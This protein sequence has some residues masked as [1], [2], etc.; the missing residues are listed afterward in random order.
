MQDVEKDILL[1]AAG[2]DLEAFET[3]YKTMANPIYN[4]A[5]RVVNSKE[6][7]EEVVQEVFLI[8]HQKLREFRFES[9]FKTW[10]YRITVNYAINYSKK[11]SKMRSVG[12]PQEHLLAAEPSSEDWQKR[13]EQDYNNKVIEELLG[14][15][16][17]EQRACVV[18]RSIEG[19][20][21]QQIADALKININTV[22]TRLKRAREKML[23][24]RKQVEYEQL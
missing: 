15:V 1:K 18:L 12:V 7:A 16:N 8:V 19:L 4:I 6:D 9:S 13:T 17:P 21:Y 11:I 24:S 23:L 20:S 5:R 10:V 2:G 3:V 22:R 14:A